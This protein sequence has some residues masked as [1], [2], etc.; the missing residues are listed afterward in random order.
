M[1]KTYL[2]IFSVVAILF[3]SCEKTR[4]LDELL[5]EEFGFS[6]REK[7]MDDKRNILAGAHYIEGEWHTFYTNS[8]Y[9]I[10][11]K[12]VEDNYII[13]TLE[14]SSKTLRGNP[15]ICF[16]DWDY[17][18]KCTVNLNAKTIEKM[19]D[20]EKKSKN[21]DIF[22]TED[23][24]SPSSCNALII[25][26]N[27][28]VRSEPNLDSTTQIIGKLNKWDDVH[29]ID[30][31][32]EKT[33]IDNLEYPWYKVQLE[34]GQEGWIFGGFAKIY[35]ID[36]D[37]HYIHKAFEKEGSEYTNQFVTPEGFY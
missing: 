10:V 7:R 20:A 34:N 36:D 33:K 29:L 25:T 9:S 24:L 3:C 28:R 13:M 17:P 4:S 6:I 23:N 32:K 1:K 27:L 35:L 37:K 21:Y 26:D 18:L 31:T 14:Y 22:V 16:F 15:E 30:C 5:K 12:E 2:L 8:Y 19:I 11:D